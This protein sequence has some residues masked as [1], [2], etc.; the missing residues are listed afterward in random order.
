VKSR[1][2][3]LFHAVADLSEEERARYFAELE[4]DTTTVREVRA[5]IQFD[6]PVSVPLERDRA[7]Q[8]EI[9]E[10]AEHAIAPPETGDILCGPYRLKNVLGRGGMGTVHLAER[11]DGEVTQQVAVKLLR[12][13]ADDASQRR[14]FL[15]ERQILAS[16]SHPNIGRLL[17][18]GHRQDG[19]P[20]LV[21]EYV[22]GKPLDVYASAFGVRR[23]VALFLKVCAAVSYLHRNLVVHRDLKPPNILVTAEGEPKL[24]DFGIAKMLDLTADSTVTGAR[25]LTPDYA[26]PEQ[27]SGNA[28]TTATDIYSL[29]AVLYKLLTGQSPHQ[30][31]GDS[32]GAIAAE[33]CHGRIIPPSKLVPALKGDL[34]TI[35]MKGLRKEPQERYATVEQFAEDLKSFLESGPIS[36]RKGEAWYRTRKFL[37]RHWVSAIAATLVVASL[38]TGLYLANRQRLIAE[39]RFA[40]LRQLSRR[41]IDLDAG[42]RTL[43]GSVEARQRL[44]A[45]SL[46]YLEGLSRDA[47]G[48]IDLAR[49]MADGYWR[50]ARIQGV[51][52]EF[53][54]G[55]HTKAEESLKKAEHLIGSVLA[56]RRSD[57]NAL[58]RSAVIAG[59]R[60]MLADSDRRYADAL[61]HAHEAARRLEIFLNQDDAKDPVRMEGFLRPGDPRSEERR[62]V[63]RLFADVA[64]ACV[65]QHQFAEGARYAWRAAELSAADPS[66]AD[67]RAQALSVLASALR[68]QGDLDGALKTIREA[69]EISEKATYPDAT[70]RFFNQYGLVYRE[71]LILGEADAANLNR[72]DEAIMLLQQNL[73]M[74]EEMAAKDPRDSASRGRVGTSAR[75]LGKILVDR[76]P[77]RALKVFDLGIARLSEAGKNLNTRREKAV[78]LAKSSDPLRRLGRT[79]EARARLDTALKMLVETKDYPSNRVQLGGPAYWVV[80]ALGD[81]EA[82][83]GQPGRALAV[84]DQLLAEIMA[85]QPN[86]LDDLRDAPKL[87]RVYEALTVLNRRMGSPGKAAAMNSQRV[88]I[89][90]HW[91][92]K[93]PDNP[94][95]R[96]ELNA[97]N[98]R[99]PVLD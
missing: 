68:Y 1:V 17:D 69:R 36:A 62:G 78:L 85:S 92:Q 87:S 52:A 26:S 82:G 44:V 28:V 39:R 31:D 97:A 66:S 98:E 32:M 12:P 43:P 18:A 33:I 75:E 61:A 99:G 8:R 11:V 83:T 80:R 72:P 46:E 95:I 65:N 94:Y 35:L 71:G 93:L 58:F 88:T 60:M 76:D 7:L 59:D 40:Q 29:G 15:A 57:R 45:A 42:I 21:M 50:M 30:F 38:T 74:T 24:L 55:D 89:W 67:M 56:T 25:M 19:Q 14:R 3:E 90:R 22:E 53:N 70:A 20:Y 49:E 34:E 51:N 6:S 96:R 81:F 2:E 5:L 47:A 27:A 73:D 84:Y 37:R 86:A 48:N 63:A 10:V 4:L 79:V 64:L 13:G 91:E 9:S 16:L 77:A 41:V 23:K 54:L